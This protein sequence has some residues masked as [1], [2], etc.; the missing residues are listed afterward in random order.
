MA[1]DRFCLFSEGCRAKK[2]PRNPREV[3]C[4]D[5]GCTYTNTVYGAVHVVNTSLPFINKKSKGKEGVDCLRRTSSS[6]TMDQR[7]TCH[8][9][10]RC[11]C[12]N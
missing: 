3:M 9:I 6:S 12:P 2:V 11:K 1:T 8:V 4:S 7:V 10:T 5:N